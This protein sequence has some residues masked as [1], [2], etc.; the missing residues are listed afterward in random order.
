MTKEQF[1][2]KH[3]LDDADFRN[4]IRYE[5]VRQS[6]RYNMYDYMGA[7]IELN[8]N[9]GKRLVDWIREGNNYEEFLEV[10]HNL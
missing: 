8:F 3:K 5:E 7:M 4:L 10:I 9:G 6:G 1:L 2:T